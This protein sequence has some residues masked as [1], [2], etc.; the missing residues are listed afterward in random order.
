VRTGFS[1]INSLKRALS[2]FLHRRG[3]PFTARPRKLGLPP[4]LSFDDV[5]ELIESLEG[6]QHR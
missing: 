5:E 1:V 3:K 4:G 6:P 2:G